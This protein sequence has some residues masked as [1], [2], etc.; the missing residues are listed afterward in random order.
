MSIYS[1]KSSVLWPFFLFQPSEIISYH[2]RKFNMEK[3]NIETCRQLV[4]QDLNNPIREEVFISLFRNI[5]I[6][7]KEKLEAI[8]LNREFQI[9]L[10]KPEVELEAPPLAEMMFHLKKSEWVILDIPEI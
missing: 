8:F 4:I 3:G 2:L 7:T 10:Y 1:A 5:P 6:W 9:C